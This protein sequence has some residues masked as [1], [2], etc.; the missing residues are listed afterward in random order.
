[1]VGAAFDQTHLKLAFQPLQLLAQ[2]GLHDVLAGGRAS[3][4]QLLGER[5]EVPKLAKLHTG[6][7]H[8]PPA[9]LAPP[10]MREHLDGNLRARRLKGNALCMAEHTMRSADVQDDG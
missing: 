10:D 8:S 1:M 9:R 7:P 3:K 2:R 5:H 4:V 6:H